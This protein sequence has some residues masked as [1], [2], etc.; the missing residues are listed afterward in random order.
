MQNQPPELQVI[1]VE[2]VTSESHSDRPGGPLPGETPFS[3]GSRALASGDGKT[4]VQVQRL[5][6]YTT[7]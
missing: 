3:D 6:F 4:F 7:N 1:P 2:K 5:G